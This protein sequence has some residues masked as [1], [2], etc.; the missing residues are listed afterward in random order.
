MP[1][2]YQPEIETALRAALETLQNERLIRT[3]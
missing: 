3:V 1:T 2:Y